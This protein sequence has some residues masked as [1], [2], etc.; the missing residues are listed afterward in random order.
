VFAYW[1]SLGL[2]I[3][4]LVIF[5]ECR[6]IAGRVTLPLGSFLMVFCYG[7]IGAPLLALLLQQI[8]IFADA[9]AGTSPITWLLGPPIE[10]LA[11]ALPVIVLAFLT[12]ESR[13][14]SI[15]DLTLIGFA[16]GAGFGFVEA[17]LNA[18]ANGAFPSVEHL[19]LFGLQ[20]ENGVVFFAGHPVTTAL[21]GL[22]A[23]IGLRFLPPKIVY[24]WVPSALMILW[25]S[26]DHGIYNWKLLNAED[27]GALPN[28]HF[29]VEFVHGLSLKGQLAAW[30]LPVTLFAA[31][32]IEAYLCSRAVGVRRDL[33][34]AREWRPWAA[35]EW[36]VALLRVRLGRAV[37][38][39]TLAYFRLR[40]AYYLAAFETR[41]DPKDPTLARHARSLE[42]RLKRERSILFDPAPGTWL[43]P[44]AVL[45][46]CALQWSWRMRWVLLFA[47]L[48]FLVF[49]LDPRSLPDWLRQFLFGETFTIVVLTAGLAFAV[50]KIILFARVPPPDP[51]AAEGTAFASHYTR[52][53]L[54]SCSLACGLFPT[55]ALLLGWKALAPGAAFI[56]GYLPGWISLGGNLQ[57]L[58]G[59][60]AIGGAVAPDPRPA[61]EAFRHE[62]AAG[63]ERI[64]RLGSE[65]EGVSTLELDSFLDAM[66][67]LDAER[68]AQ[69]R[70]QL[71]LDGCERQASEA[72]IR[73]PAPVVQ[74]IKDE[75]DRLAGELLEAAAKDLDAMAS[76]EQ[77]YAQ[78][79][80][81]VMQDLDA[82][83]RLRRQLRTPLRQAW[84]AQ[85][86]I[87]WALRVAQGTDDVL[88]PAQLTLLRELHVL[89]STALTARSEIVAAGVERIRT[90]AAE[91]G[92]NDP[93]GFAGADPA[94]DD[95]ALL[96][97]LSSVTE[98][99]E[100][101]KPF[102]LRVPQPADAPAQ[103]PD[104]G[105]DA[106]KHE[107]PQSAPSRG[108]HY[109]E[110]LDQLIEASRR[111][112]GYLETIEHLERSEEA[113]QQPVES[114]T[115]STDRPAG[116]ADSHDA[117]ES[118]AHRVEDSAAAASSGEPQGELEDLINAIK[119]DSGYLDFAKVGPVARAPEDRGQ[120]KPV[121]KTAAQ[122]AGDARKAPL[123]DASMEGTSRADE[124]PV[125][126]TTPE[127][128]AVDE[129]VAHEPEPAPVI[130]AIIDT[131]SEQ[132]ATAE[133]T[134]EVIEDT[135]TSASTFDAPVQQQLAIPQ[136][137]EDAGSS[138]PDV[139]AAPQQDEKPAL[140]EE[141]STSSATLAAKT[142]AAVPVAPEVPA[143]PVQE[144]E[145][146]AT[147]I[148]ASK[149][150][151]G[152]PAE[153]EV[154]PLETQPETSIS[155]AQPVELAEIEAPA[156]T[157][158]TIE[159]APTQP[160]AVAE[161]AQAKTAV[162]HA[163]AI[164]HAEV[165][166]A[167]DSHPPIEAKK[168]LETDEAAAKTESRASFFARLFEAAIRESSD[169]I[170]TSMP[171]G[172]LRADETNPDAVQPKTS[173]AADLAIGSAPN[174]YD[175]EPGASNET[176][177]PA[178]EWL[179]DLGALSTGGARAQAEVTPPEKIEWTALSQSM[180]EDSS[181]E[182]STSTTS[183]PVDVATPR[184]T[185]SDV[186][187]QSES[188]RTPT[189]HE[190]ASL[191]APVAE[192][193]K[194]VESGAPKTSPAETAPV[195][196]A[197]FL[198]EPTAA[199]PAATSAEPANAPA[200]EP[201]SPS[202]A[203][204]AASAD[205]SAK[206]VEPE[207][208]DEF[209]SK[210]DRLSHLLDK[211]ERAM[212]AAASAPVD[213][214]PSTT[215]A[216][217]ADQSSTQ[218][219]TS[220]MQ[221]TAAAVPT[222]PAPATTPSVVA[223][224]SSTQEQTTEATMQPAPAAPPELAPSTPPA[225]V[226]D[227]R[228]LQGQET[229]PA[230]VVSSEPAAIQPPVERTPQTQHRSLRDAKITDVLA[231]AG[232]PI[233]SVHTQPVVSQP[234][235]EEKKPVPDATIASGPSAPQQPS[236]AQLR[237][238]RLS[239]LLTRLFEAV[240]ED[241]A[242]KR[243]SPPQVGAEPTPDEIAPPASGAPINQAASEVLDLRGSDP[244][245]EPVDE[246]PSVP[247][248]PP[249]QEQQSAKVE[250]QPQ[251]I[252]PPEKVPSPVVERPA[253]PSAAV[254]PEPV[255]DETGSPD[256]SEPVSPAEAS[257]VPSAPSP[258]PNELRVEPRIRARPTAPAT[259]FGS[260]ASS[261]GAS[262]P[263]LFDMEA[264]SKA[265][266]RPKERA[267]MATHATPKRDWKL[268]N[269][270]PA[271]GEDHKSRDTHTARKTEPTYRMKTGSGA[272][273]SVDTAPPMSPVANASKRTKHYGP[274]HAIGTDDEV[275]HDTP[276]Q[277]RATN[278]AD[279]LT[280]YYTRVG[281]PQPAMYTTDRATLHRI[282]ASGK[283]EAPRRRGAPWSISGMSRRGEV[284][285]RLRP[286]S[287]QFVEFVPST[288]IFGQV[289]H[290][291]QRGVGRGNFVT[292]V[293]A[294]HLEYFDVATRQ[295]APLLRG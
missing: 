41:R 151:T 146:P 114:R 159:T 22:A 269:G 172:G 221:P 67:K 28:A 145:A 160:E 40:R 174:K 119:R 195:E 6:A 92:E 262:T 36:L 197:N 141:A 241:S 38:A 253:G 75:F 127:P 178:T 154:P 288:E 192:P 236:E 133:T 33:L 84:Q 27:T 206:V 255:R 69:A 81:E 276:A 76:L 4:F 203:A 161:Q 223:N 140:P 209:A 294:E 134:S 131:P 113:L 44:A 11:K 175:T 130:A 138:S 100:A 193:V 29:A 275:A 250:E 232:Q 46:T 239:F 201:T 249:R 207:G 214:A 284:A 224:Q 70:R 16:S 162:S 89:A 90:T 257:D 18:I 32:L 86:D 59:L 65:V 279:A 116:A 109:Q 93:F 259:H 233:A 163:E 246:P 72:T 200:P 7:S 208:T 147:T 64:R 292:H 66:A 168:A 42:D 252:A 270:D 126:L 39:Q 235:P 263:L 295:W 13:R 54:L 164:E 271:R 25:A 245:A 258:P 237:T 139:T 213:P 5:L 189:K 187:A 98:S 170:A 123:A 166:A 188:D 105:A 217:V 47:A 30:L 96:T 58:L 228:S 77:A 222:E 156:A 19:A 49:M 34:L 91:Y 129:T 220:A 20:S 88:L 264:K 74:A 280:D 50:W 268:D 169:S 199:A 2:L 210:V 290:Y 285:I 137:G 226:A 191:T 95:A 273:A 266:K 111:D 104:S 152:A 212:Q 63:E 85:N 102:G 251:P 183:I 10:E 79:W 115:S 110:A 216:G 97:E 78:A 179:A 243:V 267:D 155:Q 238:D 177:A 3:F 51:L 165:P 60:G 219:Q 142:E 230:I 73:D 121:E 118:R 17:N 186:D 144:T 61:G 14:L 198:A 26:F 48:F 234:L 1:P 101:P 136:I 240:K 24:A 31:Q 167:G 45:A 244:I 122:A 117:V 256:V 231:A 171:Q 282:I 173:D 265:P 291:Y 150:E 196:S 106:A 215:S 289:P 287:E 180:P 218:G 194:A 37:F 286:G 99:S 71:A 281:Q 254:S 80:S 229:E 57:T 260:R 185:P 202:N 132:L 23:G 120:T 293:P 62:I 272:L 52:Q 83:D 181:A 107:L 153:P 108:Q 261:L 135:P 55:L 125:A 87:R 35:N 12:R 15:A 8:P 176:S 227:Q 21:V 43:L 82:H 56:G 204:N 190:S 128:L 9:S 283:L 277:Q 103:L 157:V 248:E 112:T 278:L 211:L 149:Y 184:E 143:E 94:E 124:P 242:Y 247:S 225:N 148:E 182:Q 53:L 158:E 68:D 205:T 274:R